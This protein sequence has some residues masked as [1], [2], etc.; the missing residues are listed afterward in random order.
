MNRW[1]KHVGILTKWLRSTYFS[2]VLALEKL[3]FFEV[4][5]FWGVTQENGFVTSFEISVD[6]VLENENFCKTQENHI[7]F[8]YKPYVIKL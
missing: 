7:L 5:S 2:N 6:F 4:V 1:N 8:C 3:F